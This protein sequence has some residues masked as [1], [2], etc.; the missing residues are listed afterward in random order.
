ML[1]LQRLFRTQGLRLSVWFKRL[2]ACLLVVVKKS[3][4]YVPRQLKL[5]RTEVFEEGLKRERH[6]TLLLGALMSTK[7]FPAML[8][9]LMVYRRSDVCCLMHECPG[10]V[11][12]F[13]NL[14]TIF[15]NY[16]IW[17]VQMVTDPISW[18]RRT[19]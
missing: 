5:E 7:S 8:M 16:L 18:G 12:T 4:S 3:W 13:V 10:S 9:L 15:E 17:F 1:Q 6:G 19:F 11:R 2:L 14:N